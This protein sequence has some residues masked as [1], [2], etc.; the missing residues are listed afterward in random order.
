MAAGTASRGKIK[1]QYGGLGFS[2]PVNNFVP[3][4][5]YVPSS[6]V[7]DGDL[8]VNMTFWVIVNEIYYRNLR[9]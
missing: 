9:E 6:V 1:G 7:C 2:W 4:I 3:N 5:Y 8:G